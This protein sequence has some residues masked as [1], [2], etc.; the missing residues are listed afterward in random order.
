M[1]MLAIIQDERKSHLLC[2]GFSFLGY[3]NQCY[4]GNSRLLY[5]CINQFGYNSD[6]EYSLHWKTA[7]TGGE[8]EQE[9]K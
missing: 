3:W 1:T 6:C 8:G 7:G 5:G 9:N 2:V 4:E